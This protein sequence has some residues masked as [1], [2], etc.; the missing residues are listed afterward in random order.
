MIRRRVGNQ[1]I[2]ITQ[3]DHARL[4]GELARHLG[5]SRYARPSPF[6][7]FTAAVTLHDAGWP[8]H[9]RAPE[10]NKDG[11]PIDV[12]ETTRDIALRVWPGAPIA[13]AAGGPWAELLV[14][15]HILALSA[16]IIARSAG[17]REDTIPARF[18]MNKFQHR[19]IERQENL[20]RRLGLS[21]EIPLTL[22]LADENETSDALEAHLRCHLRWLQAMDALSLALCCTDVPIPHVEIHAQPGAYT[23]TL[24]FRRDR[25]DVT[26]TP[27]PFAGEQIQ[28]DIPCRAIPARQ[29]ATVADLHAEIAGATPQHLHAHVK[30]H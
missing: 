16:N 17:G 9:D 22:G 21:T 3:D 4:S 30:P 1:F 10:L 28:V 26:V 29:Y 24:H 23:E 27:W 18:E 14:S 5:T 13:T 12:F 19:E 25:N 20:R 6:D 7:E 8:E 15:L 2:L 11:Y